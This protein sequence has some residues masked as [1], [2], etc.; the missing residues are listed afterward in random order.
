VF[1]GD[2]RAFRS[3]VSKVRIYLKKQKTLIFLLIALEQIFEIIG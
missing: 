2:E 3:G 1:V